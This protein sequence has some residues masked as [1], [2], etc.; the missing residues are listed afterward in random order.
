MICN[1]HG[2]FPALRG[3]GR[4]NRGEY[5]RQLSRFALGWHADLIGTSD[6]SVQGKG[7]RRGKGRLIGK[8]GQRELS[9]KAENLPLK[10]A[11]WGLSNSR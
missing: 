11:D 2:D 10:A 9:L 5:Q 3:K 6:R 1:S 7:G 8:E 4:S